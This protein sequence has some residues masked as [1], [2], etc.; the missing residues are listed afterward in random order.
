MA[1]TYKDVD[2]IC[3]FF[4]EQAAKYISCEGLTEDSIIKL[5]F[6]VQKS[7][8]LHSDVFCEG[9]YKNCEIYRMLEAKYE[10]A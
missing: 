1:T 3:P 7:K 4:R 5:W 8:E 6:R 10:E 2:V 9:K